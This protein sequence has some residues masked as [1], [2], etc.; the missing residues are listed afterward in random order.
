[1][2]INRKAAIPFSI[3]LWTAFCI[4]SL[5]VHSHHLFPG[6]QGDKISNNLVDGMTLTGL[7]LEGPLQQLYTS[8]AL[9]ATVEKNHL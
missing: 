4:C 7:H 5:L 1:M 9:F 3:P 6:Y 2:D 8:F